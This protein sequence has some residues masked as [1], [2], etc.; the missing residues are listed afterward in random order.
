MK[1]VMLRISQVRHLIQVLLIGQELDSGRAASDKVLV[2]SIS[3]ESQDEGSYKHPRLTEGTL[4]RRLQCTSR[5][6]S[7]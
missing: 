1:G 5:R 4:Q 7:V 2:V 6:K 3:S